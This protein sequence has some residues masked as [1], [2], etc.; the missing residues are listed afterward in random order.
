MSM[1]LQ[2][3]V[4]LSEELEQQAERIGVSPEQHATELL[5]VAAVVAGDAPLPPSGVAVYRTEAEVLLL[6]IR[7][8]LN[9]EPRA[10]A[11]NERLRRIG[12]LLFKLVQGK[13][14]QP[15]DSPDAVNSRP[16]ALGKYAHIPGTSEDF[17][18]RKQE[19][20]DREDGR[21]A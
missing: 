17:A 5:S 11:D 15:A 4:E 10:E 7:R 3:P 1:T 6:M 14:S 8:L 2:L 19:E 20:I 12:T 18:R 21:A 9:E 16:S 13:T